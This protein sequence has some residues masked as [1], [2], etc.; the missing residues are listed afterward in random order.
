[1]ATFLQENKLVEREMHFNGYLILKLFD[2]MHRSMPVWYIKVR[3]SAGLYASVITLK[4]SFFIGFNE[5]YFRT[6][7][8]NL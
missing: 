1:M 4:S 5:I 8:L 7:Q 3:N 6:T 2:Q